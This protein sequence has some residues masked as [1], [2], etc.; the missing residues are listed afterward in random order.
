M[1]WK[2][3]VNMPGLSIYGELISHNVPAMKSGQ[4]P[5]RQHK[6]TPSI[7]NILAVYLESLYG[8]A[9]HL[10]TSKGSAMSLSSL[11]L[12]SAMGSRV[13]LCRSS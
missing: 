6:A 8:V 7:S 13:N 10:P 11:V 5:S 12:D 9:D 4:V 2:V 1:L 3:S